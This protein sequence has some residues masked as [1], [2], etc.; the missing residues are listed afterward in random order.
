MLRRLQGL[1]LWCKSTSHVPMAT[2]VG[3]CL[4]G[5]MGHSPTGRQ[6]FAAL[7]IRGQTPSTSLMT[8]AFSVSG[9]VYNSFQGVWNL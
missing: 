9:N 6:S 5:L 2:L 3:Q 8:K 4:P 1:P 7:G